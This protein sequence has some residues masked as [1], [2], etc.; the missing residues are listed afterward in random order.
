LSAALAVPRFV[1]DHTG[2]PIRNFVHTARRY[3]TVH[4]R[5]SNHCSLPTAPLAD[6]LHQALP[7]ISG[8]DGTH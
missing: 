3:R 2:W 8:Q 1:E 5:T 7:R 6:D 4:I